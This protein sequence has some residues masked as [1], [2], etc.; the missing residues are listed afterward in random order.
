[1]LNNNEG[2]HQ[3]LGLRRLKVSRQLAV[4][5]ALSTDQAKRKRF[6]TEMGP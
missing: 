3:D 4:R 1:M 6:A 5:A 2:V